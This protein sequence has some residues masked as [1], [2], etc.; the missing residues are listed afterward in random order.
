M[1]SDRPSITPVANRSDS[2]PPSRLNR[3]GALPPP[4]SVH[5]NALLKKVRPQ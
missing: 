3:G 2:A 4:V 5:L 1:K